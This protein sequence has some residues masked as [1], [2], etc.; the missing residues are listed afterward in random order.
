ME[1]FEHLDNELEKNPLIDREPMDGLWE[2]R[3]MSRTGLF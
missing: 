1:S 2:T 3:G